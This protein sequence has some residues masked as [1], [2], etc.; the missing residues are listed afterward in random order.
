MGHTQN[1]PAHPFSH[2]FMPSLDKLTA[3]SLGRV[4]RPLRTDLVFVLLWLTGHF[5]RERFRKIG[6][7]C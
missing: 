5:S 4:L 2:S 6:A 1:S 7:K 3:A